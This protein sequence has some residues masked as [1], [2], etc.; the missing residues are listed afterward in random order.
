VRFWAT[1]LLCFLSIALSAQT[2]I[3]T[4]STKTDTTAIQPLQEN[5][6]VVRKRNE[7]H[8]PKKAAMLSAIVPGLGQ[9]YNRKY[10]KVP[11]VYGILGGVSY[12]AYNNTRYYKFWHDGLIIKNAITNGQ[13]TNADFMHFATTHKYRNIATNLDA[14]EL[15]LLSEAQFQ[16]ENDSYRRNRDLSFFFLGILYMCNVL[17]ATVDGHLYNFNVSD[18]LS[19]HLQPTYISSFSYYNS[20]GMGLSISAKF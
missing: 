2:T 9:V 13:K 14:D 3:D 15:S 12:L 17:D 5:Q 11:I 18:D 6:S 7:D 4:D 1:Y 8:S 19:F 16:T 10:W 20:P